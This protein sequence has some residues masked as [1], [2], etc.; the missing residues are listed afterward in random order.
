MR[1]K[2]L[3]VMVSCVSLAGAGCA[4]AR[5]NATAAPP[6]AASLSHQAAPTSSPAPGIQTG[7]IRT[8]ASAAP[9]KKPAPQ[10]PVA[11]TEAVSAADERSSL[12]GL[13][14]AQAQWAD[15]GRSLVVARPD[16]A[17]APPVPIFRQAIVLA[18]VRSALAGCPAAPTAEFR[19]GLL[20]LTFPRGTA[21]EIATA[22]N[23]AISVPGVARLGVLIES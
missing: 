20:T 8:P 21:A 16:A 12:P 9:K 10:S 1:R 19:H 17:Q 2:N 22:I 15:Y 11:A 3:V 4:G 23:R 14:K 6:S 18:A 5:K 7:R 13:I